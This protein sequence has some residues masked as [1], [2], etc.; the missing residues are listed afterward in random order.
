MM[1]VLSGAA[2]VLPDRILSPGTL[3]IDG[4]RIA[5]IRA[6]KAEER[7]RAKVNAARRAQSQRGQQQ[8]AQQKSAGMGPL[9]GSS[10]PHHRRSAPHGPRRPWPR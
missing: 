7:A 3:V 4:E 6:R 10:R 5:E 8:P 2:L 1:I 9:D